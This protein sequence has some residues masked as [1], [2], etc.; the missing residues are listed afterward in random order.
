MKIGV[1]VIGSMQS[2]GGFNQALS[3]VSQVRRLCEGRFEIEVY[4]CHEESLSILKQLGFTAKYLRFALSDRLAVLANVHPLFGRFMRYVIPAGSFE[5][6][7]MRNGVDLVYFT[8]PCLYS[9]ALCRL[10]YICT[11]WDLCHR[12]APEFPEVRVDGEFE[13]RELL[14]RTSLSKAYLVL[15]DSPE[16]AGR[17]EHRYGIDSER[18]L[19]MP[20]SPAPFLT[21][22]ST[23]NN[24]NNPIKEEYF[25]YPAQ[26][27]SHK[28]HIRILE[29]LRLLKDR[30]VSARVAFCGKDYGN[31]NWV[32]EQAARLGVADQVDFLGFV[33]PE[34]MD[35][36]YDNCLAVLMPT[37]FG[38]TNI[39]PL[40]AWFKG[41]PLI[42]SEHLRGQSRDAALLVDPD[43]AESLADGIVAMLHT[44]VREEYASRGRNRLEEIMS[45]RNVSEEKLLNQLIRFQLRRMLWE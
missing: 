45:E 8:A 32:R 21:A 13:S 14:N 2:G 31:L 7:L 11:V 29:A 43:S 33:S 9:V 27:W 17:V 4:C 19:P 37:Y 20:F 23:G 40:E 12:D 34:E 3:A 6:R 10:N 28:N 36:L 30:M 22:E 1:I 25:F 41:K 26:F 38:P 18:I 39:P 35:S 5:R 24:K 44:E 42:Y 16:L 15:T